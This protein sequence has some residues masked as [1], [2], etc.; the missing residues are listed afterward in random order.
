[1]RVFGSWARGE[2]STQSDLD[3]LVRLEPGRSLLDLIGFEQALEDRLGLS[4]DIVTEGALSPHLR[5]RVVSE[6]RALSAA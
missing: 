3:L 4:V 6:A 1:V 5:A 2:A